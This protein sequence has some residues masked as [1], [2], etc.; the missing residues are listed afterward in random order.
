MPASPLTLEEID[1]RREA[2]RGAGYPSPARQHELVEGESAAGTV[3]RLPA[4]NAVNGTWLFL[5]TT[6][7]TV[8]IPASAKRG[9]TVLARLLED[10]HVAVGDHVTVAYLGKR[11]TADGEREYRDYRLEVHHAG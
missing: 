4:W 3:L 5:R 6:Q 9:H 10:E 7:E 2:K 11:R 1:R 8:C